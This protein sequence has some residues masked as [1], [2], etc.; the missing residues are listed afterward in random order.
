MLPIEDVLKSK[1]DIM[2]KQYIIIYLYITKEDIQTKP[3]NIRKFWYK[4]RV[5]YNKYKGVLTCQ[6]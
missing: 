1:I 6:L 5:F 4:G 3:I 2:H